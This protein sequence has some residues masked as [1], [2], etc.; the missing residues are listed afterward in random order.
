MLLTK[1][2]YVLNGTLSWTRKHGKFHVHQSEMTFVAAYLKTLGA[3][4]SHYEN[5]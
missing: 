5:E 2:K 3:F 4:V 1:S